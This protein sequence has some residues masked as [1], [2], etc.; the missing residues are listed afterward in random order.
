MGSGDRRLAAIMFTD[1][2]GYTRMA[3]AR[4]SLALELLEEHR[5]VV[6]PLLPLHGGTEI[7]TMGDAFL[8]EFRSALEAV[9]CAVEIQEKMAER[10]SKVQAERRL[11]IRIG[12]HLGDVVHGAGDVYGDAVNI[13]SRIEPLAE[14]GGVCIS[15][16]VYDN[17]RNKSDLGFVRM[18]DV[19]LKNVELPMAVYRI[20]MTGSG[21]TPTGLDAPRERLAVLPFINISPDPNDEY[22]ADGMTEEL[23][24]KLSEIKG[25]KVIARTS[26]MNYK[27]K[28]KNVSQIGRELDVGSVIEG[29]VRKAGSKIRV[30]VQ[31][32]D[33]KTQEHLWASNYDKELDD[34]FAIQSDVANKVA[35]SLSA[36]VFSRRDVKETDDL[37]AYTAYLRANQ[38]L[39]EGSE[40]NLT[41]AVSLFEKATSR[42]P[43]FS[44]AYAG[45][46]YAWCELASGGYV[47]FGVGAEKAEA[48]ARS[49]LETGPERAES[50]AAMANVH[51]MLD[52]YPESTAEAERA[53]QINPN[54]S[55]A[56]ASLGVN[57]SSL[58]KV[59]D[60]L[61]AFQKAY[62]LDPLSRWPGNYVAYILAMTRRVNEAVDILERL[63]DLHPSHPRSYVT[64]AECY[65][66]AG[67]YQKA[68]GMLDRARTI[69]PNDNTLRIGQGVLYAL[70]GRGEEA[71]EEESE[72]EKG[73]VRSARLYG[74][75]FIE[76][77]MGNLDE[78]FDA[79]MQSAEL[80][81]WP[82]LIGLNP[83]FAELRKDPRYQEFKEKVGLPP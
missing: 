65:I 57:Y 5:R 54:L 25:L 44:R 71:K 75:L 6:R 47:D 62:A 2:V 52:R 7:K 37:E 15:Q 1:I 45:L 19:E 74:R 12:V 77:A 50:H 30:S 28:D 39:H 48:A 79:L 46:A 64:I 60:A 3:Q 76:A 11:D 59:D 51:Y 31:L 8:V 24:S 68:Q 22:F 67:E 38:L 70:T 40:D 27:K 36:G 32:V 83:L 16:Q 29:S 10:N 14:P 81:S 61:R 55:E 18:G 63:R 58:G 69:A 42:V 4:E 49:S 13:A 73:S 80:H 72:I 53:L 41:Q 33:S 43:T 35:D 26:V 20:E 9:L 66:M 82:F 78:A 23:I 56:Y 21:E 34:I 17:I